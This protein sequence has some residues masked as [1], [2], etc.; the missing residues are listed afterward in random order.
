MFESIRTHK[1]YLMAFL[2]VLIVP[3]FVLW[4]VDGYTSLTQRSEAV[5]SI[6]GEEITRDEWEQAHQN[7]VRRM[8]EQM[9]DLDAKLLDSPSARYGTL[10]ALVRDR[11]LSTAANKFHIVISKERLSKALLQDPT[12]AQLKNE[13]GSLDLQAYQD[14]LAGNG[15]TPESYEANYRANMAR[16][17]II[18]GITTTTMPTEAVADVALDAFF[19]KRE[20]SFKTFLAKDFKD[21]VT[22]SE[23]EIKSFYDANQELFQAAES[24]DIEYV[25]LD[26]ASLSKT[27]ELNEDEVKAYFEQNKGLMTKRRASHILL[28]LPADA[29]EEGRAKVLANAQAVL[30]EVRK[31]PEKFAEI[32]RRES[33]DPG[34]SGNGGDLGFIA[35]NAMV[36]PFEDAVFALKSKGEISDLVETEF[37]YHIIE[38][39]DIQPPVFEEVRQDIEKD[40]RDQQSQ[41]L[42]AEN[43]EAFA[44]LTYN[45]P[46][47][48]KPVADKFG[49]RVETATGITRNGNPEAPDAVNAPKLLEA[50][51][52]ADSLEDKNNTPA[53]EAGAGKLVAARVT[54]HDPRHVQ[55]LTEVKDAVKT[56]LVFERSAAMAKEEGQKAL[57]QLNAGANGTEMPAPVTVSRN[58]NQGVPPQVL[59]AA[60]SAAPEKLPVF[61]GVDLGGSG[62]AVVKVLS[63]VP[64]DK[65]E[66]T[67]RISEVGQYGQWWG[68]AEGEAYYK[69]LEKMLEVKILVPEPK[70]TD[71]SD[72]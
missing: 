72:S 11:V 18:G 50:L 65:P 22:P 37:G 10:T 34:S 52:A 69:L 46:D 38:L 31:A 8:Q 23:E 36:K 51:F 33:Q 32:A 71:T 13:D 3:S 63:V 53:V 70:L 25:V 20:I 45:Q 27:M 43:A 59:D 28:T 56:Q 67:Q 64:R 48:L 68:S 6:A 60:L 29:T 14:L 2:L 49:L 44:N 17:Q 35:P 19:Q 58:G 16:Q 5:A 39:T 9:P 1:K 30:A 47:S 21:K 4:G 15:L 24:V 40:I 55:A 62:Y 7:Q 26:S 54:R 42:F 66:A 12:L 41:K 57:E 61:K